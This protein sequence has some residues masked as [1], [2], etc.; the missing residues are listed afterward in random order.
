MTM[1]SL[2]GVGDVEEV[3][4]EE[5][6]TLSAPIDTLPCMPAMNA[7]NWS[8]KRR[9]MSRLL[10]ATMIITCCKSNGPTRGDWNGHAG[11][12]GATDECGG[13]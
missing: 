1:F 5:P 13:V 3:D 8:D 12:D 7:A 10:S 9:E 2:L 6:D 4:V 11:G